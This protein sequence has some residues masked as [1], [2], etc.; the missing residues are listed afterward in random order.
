MKPPAVTNVPWARL[1]MPPRPVTTTNDRNTIASA[2]PGREDA[3]T[4]SKSS[5]L[6]PAPRAATAA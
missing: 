2:M 1:T 5:A 4:T 3:R 6:R